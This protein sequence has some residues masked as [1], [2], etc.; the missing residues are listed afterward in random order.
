[1]KNIMFVVLSLFVFIISPSLHAEQK[2]SAAKLVLN[3]DSLP[4]LTRT[5]H[6]N[7]LAAAKQGDLE[8]LRDIFETNELAPD[9]SDDHINDPIDYWKGQSID[10][11]GRDIMASIIEVFS[12]PPVKTKD[13][14]YIWPYLSQ[15]PLNKLTKAQAIDLFRLAG[16]AQASK[17]LKDNRYDY[18]EAKIG[19]DGTWHS[20]KRT[21][22]SK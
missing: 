6:E 7:L 17:M 5:M 3:L 9:L 8:E 12:L 13:G 4:Q 19:K 22:T 15:I 2:K 11:S 18:F 20:F 1:M 14:D 10:G 16:P 21:Q